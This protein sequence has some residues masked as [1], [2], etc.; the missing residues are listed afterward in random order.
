MFGVNEEIRFRAR[1]STIGLSLGVFMV[2][3]GLLG[4]WEM[5]G[6]H[7]LRGLWIGGMV[8]TGLAIIF[9]HVRR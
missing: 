9:I 7:L 6:W 4:L 8:G 2:C 5:F 1:L 3:A